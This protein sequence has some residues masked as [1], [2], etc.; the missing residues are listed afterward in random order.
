MVSY[1]N[2]YLSTSCLLCKIFL[3]LQQAYVEMESILSEVFQA[4][5]RHHLL[6]RYLLH[7][8]SIQ[9]AFGAIREQCRK[10]PI[11]FASWASDDACT[12][13]ECEL[14]HHTAQ[15]RVTWLRT[16]QMILLSYRQLSTQP[17][18]LCQLHLLTACAVLTYI[19]THKST[20]LQCCRFWVMQG[21]PWQRTLGTV[22]RI[23]IWLSWSH[24]WRKDL[25]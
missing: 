4:K 10:L 20:C 17:K 11:K 6:Q 15:M 3:H 23:D 16:D 9:V 22:E 18:F 14:S 25:N 13:N 5:L 8:C 24:R 2:D 12:T 1:Q 7:L 21:R 19:F